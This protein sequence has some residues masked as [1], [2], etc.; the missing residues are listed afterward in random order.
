MV[1]NA[2]PI[3]PVV[4]AVIALARAD[5]TLIG[6]CPETIG[7]TG[8][9]AVYE[10][11]APERAGYP[12]LVVTDAG[13]VPNNTIGRG[14]GWDVLVYFRATARKRATAKSVG[15]RVIAL[16]DAPE[17][18]LVVAGWDT[19]LS[20]IVTDGP[21]YPEALDGDTVHHYPVAVRVTVH[22]LN[23]GSPA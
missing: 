4:A 10:E 3:E 12:Y 11:L 18:A 19:A 14:W 13:A 23:V 6:L 8:E 7:S 15:S 17:T 22:G 20:E 21:G 1:A 9:A 16:F 2:S 5:A